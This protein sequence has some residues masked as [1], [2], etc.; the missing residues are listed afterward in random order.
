MMGY[1]AKKVVL[2]SVYSL[3]WW[4]VYLGLPKKKK[5]GKHAINRISII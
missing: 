1:V 4:Q 2:E 3:S 5:I